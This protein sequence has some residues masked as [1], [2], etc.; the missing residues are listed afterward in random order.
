MEVLAGME[1]GVC[2]LW[3]VDKAARLFH[4]PKAF[5]EETSSWILSKVH[6]GNSEF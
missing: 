1:D 6:F 5:F 4:V 3:T 2:F